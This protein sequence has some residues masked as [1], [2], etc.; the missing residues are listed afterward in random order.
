VLLKAI[1]RGEVQ[2]PSACQVA[3]CARTERLH[4]HHDDY[5]KQ[6]DV[7]WL[8]P[9]HHE[10]AHH[11]GPQRLKPG[12]RRKFARPP[13]LAVRTEKATQTYSDFAELR[14]QVRA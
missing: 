11:E 13:R 6:C 9:F 1:R 3:G 4:A 14:T 8:C 10:A 7:I 5:S 2:R 12:S